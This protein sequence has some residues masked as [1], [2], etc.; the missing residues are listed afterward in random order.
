MGKESVMKILP[1][2]M[3]YARTRGAG[4]VRHALARL[5]AKYGPRFHPDTGWDDLK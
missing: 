1:G 3:H 2:P 5:A 4:D